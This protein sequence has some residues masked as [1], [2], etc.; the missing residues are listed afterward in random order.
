[1]AYFLAIVAIPINISPRSHLSNL[2]T[3]VSADGDTTTDC[4]AAAL[5]S[6]SDGQISSNGQ[7]VS[8]PSLIPYSSFAASPYIAAISTTFSVTNDSYL[9]WKNSAFTGAKALFC[10]MGTTVQAVYNGELPAGCAQINLAYVPAS[11]CR[12]DNP[13]SPVT[14]PT[15]STTGTGTGTSSPPPTTSIP[16]SIRGIDATANPLGCLTSSANS[17]AVLGNQL[18]RAVSTLV[19]CLDFCSSSTYFGVQI[20][21]YRCIG[22]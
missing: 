19:E 8:A 5:F 17:P 1:M 7:I 6:V 3:F 16:G 14:E 22:I 21:K 15:A 20:G 12:T 4:S 18:L 2:S 13:S 9:E 11:S 10:V